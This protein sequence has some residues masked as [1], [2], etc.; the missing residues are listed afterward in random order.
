[1]VPEQ[2]IMTESV[3]DFIHRGGGGQAVS[4]LRSAIVGTS[5][6]AV[7]NYYH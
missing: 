1:M 4:T 7:W 6:I 3:R 5:L 2:D